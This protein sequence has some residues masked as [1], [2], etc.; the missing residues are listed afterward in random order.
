MPL[1][2]KT[3]V[4]PQILPELD[5]M[6]EFAATLGVPFRQDAVLW[7]TFHGRDVSELRLPPAKVVEIEHVRSGLDDVYRGLY[8]SRKLFE[9]SDPNYDPDRLFVCG[10]G[11]QSCYVDP[12]GRLGLC[13]MSRHASLDLSACTFELSW[14]KLDALR[15]TQISKDFACMRCSIAGLCQRCPAMSM[16]ENGDPET[17]VDHVCTQ[18]HL[19]AERLG[20][21]S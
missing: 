16:V 21:E 10:A 6:T 2:L 17:V 5:A 20:I 1:R 18:A 12:Y 8:E 9:A 14:Q 7:Q 19:W 3:M 4:L 11:Y 13:Q 15:L